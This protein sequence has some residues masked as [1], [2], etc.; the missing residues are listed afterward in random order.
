LFFISKKKVKIAFAVGLPLL[1]FIIVFLRL[2]KSY[3]YNLHR[4]YKLVEVFFKTTNNRNQSSVIIAALFFI[5]LSTL[6]VQ[7]YNLNHLQTVA[8]ALFIFSILNTALF[9]FTSRPAN[10]DGYY[11]L[12]TVWGLLIS[13]ITLQKYSNENKRTFIPDKIP[14]Y[15]LALIA[16]IM[17]MRIRYISDGPSKC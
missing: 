11:F 6:L 12:P 7:L 9:S 16:F 1:G 8:P 4:S 2:T 17:A 5:L 14:K 13:S 3:S 10:L 15:A